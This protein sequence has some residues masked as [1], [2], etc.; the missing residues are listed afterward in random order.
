MKIIAMEHE[1]PGAI[2]KAFQ[3]YG[4]EEAERVWEL[5]QQGIVR[6][7]YFRADRKEAILILECDNPDTAR[8]ILETLPMVRHGLITF[9]VI[10]LLPYSGFA[11]L[12]SKP[13]YD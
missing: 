5:H 12:F 13:V 11:R 4:R 6:E 10:P 3:A 9:E 7:M 2:T 1:A 8:N